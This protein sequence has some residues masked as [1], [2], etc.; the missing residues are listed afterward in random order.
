MTLI[1]PVLMIVLPLL[2]LAIWFDHRLSKLEKVMKSKVWMTTS[3]VTR[4]EFDTLKVLVNKLRR[5]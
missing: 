1:I 5:K 3:E 4:Q 2:G